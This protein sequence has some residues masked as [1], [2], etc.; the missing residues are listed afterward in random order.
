MNKTVRRMKT[1]LKG[2]VCTF[3]LLT[4]AV[5]ISGQAVYAADRG[6]SLKDER[7]MA[8]CVNPKTDCRAVVEDDAGLLN[9]KERA[10][11]LEKMEDITEF[12][13]VAFKSVNENR[14]S[15]EAYARD[16][17]RE[18]FGDSG[19][20]LFVVDMDN[21]Y[22]YLY[23]HGKIYQTITEE[24]ANT[25]TDNVYRYASRE[26]YYSCAWNV[27]DQ[28]C[29]V[30]DGQKIAMPMKY[31]CN[32]LLAVNLGLL[33]NYFLVKLL[34]GKNSTSAD[35]VIRSEQHRLNITD[36]T[37]QYRNTTKTYSPTSSGSSGGG[38]SSHSGGGS[39]SSGGSHSGGSSGG[40]GGHSF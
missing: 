28:A 27:Y 40:G 13:N 32:I 15:T 17:Y 22:I 19:G 31:I 11:L 18:L 14:N 24:Y 2:L 10:D 9:E 36:V 3:L 29:K 5:S 26:D 6:P 34:T 37:A 20:L 21:R 30:L 12:G 4:A 39:H 23:S 38:G 16:H 25:I 35:D 1:C 7:G 8:V 33:I